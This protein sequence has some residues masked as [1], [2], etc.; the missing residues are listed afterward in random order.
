MTSH[1]LLRPFRAA[2]RLRFR[3]VLLSLTILLTSSTRAELPAIRFDRIQPLGASAGA[4]VEVEVKGRDI[5]DVKSLRFDHPG[6]KAEWVKDGRFKITIAGDVPPSTYDARLVGR[7]GVSNPRVFAVSH[8]LTDVE[9]KEPNNTPDKAQ[10]VVINVAVNGTCDGNGQ[11]LFRFTARKGQRLTIECEAGKLDSE[12]DAS[13]TI[14]TA[15]GSIVASS[16]DYFGRDPFIDFVAPEDGD[17]L[18]VLHDLSY[19]GGMPYRLVISD[20]PHVENLFPRAVEPGK[21]VELTAYGRNFGT[22]GQASPWQID[23]RALEAYRFTYTPPGDGLKLGG[24]RFF[25]HPTDH[26]VLPTAATCTLIGEQV[27]VPIGSSAMRPQPVVFSTGP[28]TLDAEPNDDLKKPQEVSLPLTV[29]GRFDKP[30]DADWFTFTAAESGPHYVE[31]FSERIAGRADPFV[32][33]LDEKDNRLAEHDDFGHRIQAFDG[34][35]RDPVG[36]VNLEKDKR[37]R[38]LVQ[39]RYGRG[40]ARF[41]YV[42]TLRRP[43]PDF[44]LAA[45]HRENQEPAGLN[46]WR[47]GSTHL[48]IVSHQC[49]GFGAPLTITAEGLPPGVHAAPLHMNVETRGTFVLWSDPDAPETVAPFRL[50]A[51]GKRGDEELRHEVR[52]YA[53]V[54][55]NQNMN[56]SRPMRELVVGTHDKAPFGLR[57]EPETTTVEQNSKLE[58][59]VIATRYASDFR[60]EV[61]LLTLQMP[62][63]IKMGDTQIAAG[64]TE[65]KVTLEIATPRTGKHT[66]AIQGQAQVPYNKD[67]QAT[68]RP[69]TLVS[70]PT[71]PIT[72]NVV[73][74]PK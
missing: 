61:K 37:Y 42:L 66:F 59:K 6:L 27:R 56:S 55:A 9:E 15:T 26:T 60:A 63:G 3:A 39:D 19:R 62:G 53:K 14:T 38:V 46:L 5:E 1:P 45:I 40:G 29:S 4:N 23:G 17:Y 57:I 54:W 49:D 20:Q 51:V 68:S 31:V 44:F 74:K 58:V 7:F 72:L 30:R 67:P 32:V 11:D 21:P 25:E 16:G 71:R 13:M 50:V 41:Q 10:P 18:I 47:G 48:D 12:L 2:H 43:L 69:N 22:A 8:G 52:P 64:G 70:V 73:A 36:N 35:L 65:A 34:H 24:Y 28:V 33:V